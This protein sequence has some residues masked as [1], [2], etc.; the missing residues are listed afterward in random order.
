MSCVQAVSK[1][2]ALD[3]ALVVPSDA[4][5]GCA[6]IL[7][8]GAWIMRMC[9]SDGCAE[10]HDVGAR[11]MRTRGCSSLGCAGIPDLGVR[12]MRIRSGACG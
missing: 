11:F 6:E 7:D 10:I 9:G 2:H 1:I 12:I 4:L 3:V 8:I 5:K